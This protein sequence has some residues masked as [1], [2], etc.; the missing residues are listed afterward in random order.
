MLE[1]VEDPRGEREHT[2]AELRHARVV[3]VQVFCEKVDAI[4]QLLTGPKSKSRRRG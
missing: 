1:L 2:D 4:K 3:A